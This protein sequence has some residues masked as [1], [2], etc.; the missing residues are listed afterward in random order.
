M[1]LLLIRVFCFIALCEYCINS[2]SL[3]RIRCAGALRNTFAGLFVYC[4][5]KILILIENTTHILLTEMNK[6]F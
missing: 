1:G 2:Y 5:T 3:E 6:L 4:N